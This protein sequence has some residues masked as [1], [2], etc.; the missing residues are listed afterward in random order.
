MKNRLFVIGN[1]F[2]L[3]H[4]LPTSF[5]KDFKRIAISNEIDKDFWEL[6]QTDV[7]DIWSDFENSLGHPDFNSL[8]QIFDG[9]YLDYSS[10]HESDRDAIITLAGISGNLNKSLNDFATKDG[11]L[12]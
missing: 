8:E 3:A 9:Y 4:N 1:G 7:V 5:D 2:D 12:C 10:D 11:Y 6:Y